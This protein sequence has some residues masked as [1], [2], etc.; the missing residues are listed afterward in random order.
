M[1][2]LS[3]WVSGLFTWQEPPAQECLKNTKK[4]RVAA[5]ELVKNKG[6]GEVRK[7]N[8]VKKGSDHTGPPS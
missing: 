1:K 7:E 8:R 6:G 2:E 3:V 5:A 4:K